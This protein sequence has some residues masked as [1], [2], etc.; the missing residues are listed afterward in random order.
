MHPGSSKEVPPLSI[1]LLAERTS[2]AGQHS[3]PHPLASIRLR[4]HL[5]TIINR[6]IMTVSL[7]H[8]HLFIEI[9][10][11]CPR[12]KARL[13]AQSVGSI[14]ASCGF[15]CLLE[16]MFD[17]SNPFIRTTRRRKCHARLNALERIRVAY[18]IYATLRTEVDT[19]SIDAMPKRERRSNESRA[20]VSERRHH[21][22]H[23][24]DCEDQLNR[25]AIV[26]TSH[27][28]GVLSG[29][30]AEPKTLF[31]NQS[32]GLTWWRYL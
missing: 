1:L 23:Y 8:L 12:L 7:K 18:C 5:H 24:G 9:V 31:V 11:Y 32:Q 26:K 2:P 21:G 17:I 29:Y 27:C 22:V 28:H 30:R 10:H 4:L 6:H 15:Q 14:D 25:L 20:P 16:F 3:Q 13:G 19:A